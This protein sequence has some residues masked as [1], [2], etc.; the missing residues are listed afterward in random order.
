MSFFLIIYTRPL[1]SQFSLI[2]INVPGRSV[3]SNCG[4]YYTESIHAYLDLHLQSLAQA[5]ISYDKDTNN[6]L[7]KLRSLP[8]LPDNILLCTVDVLGFYPVVPH[9]ENQSAVRNWLDD[10]M[11]KY[12]SG[13]MLYDL[14]EV[15]RK[16]NIFKFV[17]KILK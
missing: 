5:V 10:R 13:D 16:N 15:V 17:K 14:A 4:Y 8:K 6:F 1:V 12:T 3:I 7:N 2:F 9:K 11:E